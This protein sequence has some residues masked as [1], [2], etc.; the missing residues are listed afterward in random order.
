[1][2]FIKNT[3]KIVYEINYKLSKSNLVIQSFGN[4]SQ[5]VSESEFIIKPSGVNLDTV[6]ENDMSHIYINNHSRNSGLKP[7]SD[8]PTHRE[9][10]INSDF[11]G[12]IVHTH[13]QYA[14]A[15]AQAL[16][17]IENL[18]TTQ[19]DYVQNSILCSRPL[20]RSEVENDYE[21]N[22]GTVIHETLKKQNLDYS[23][24]PG[25]LVA[26]HGVF[27]WGENLIEAFKNAEIIEYLAK[28]NL[29][30]KSLNPEQLSIPDYLSNKHFNRKHGPHSY[31]GQ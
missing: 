29:L 7:S 21:K 10:Y 26:H 25:I 22:T 9:I 19:S 31:Y 24:V 4:G 23:D 18:G 6:D 15:Y 16:M 20:T 8:E 2:E 30:T 17:E 11:I 28:M 12:G 13:S 27:S 3:K 1:M 14:T 5:R